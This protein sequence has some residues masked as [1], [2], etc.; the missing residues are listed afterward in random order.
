MQIQVHMEEST[1]YSVIN[2][3]VCPIS[4]GQQ[5]TKQ[6]KRNKEQKEKQNVQ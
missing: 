3:E 2:I 6:G 4:D 5:E 1:P